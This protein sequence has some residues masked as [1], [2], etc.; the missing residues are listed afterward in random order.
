LILRIR[1]AGKE[2]LKVLIEPWYDELVLSCGQCC[3]VKIRGGTVEPEVEVVEGGIV[4]YGWA[5][6]V[7][8]LFELET[9]N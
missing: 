6:S 5:D 7:L 4:V 9:R 1:N 2:N 3:I 8:E